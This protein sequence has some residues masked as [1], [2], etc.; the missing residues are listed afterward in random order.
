MSRVIPCAPRSERAIAQVA[1]RL[2][3]AGELN[4]L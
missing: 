4:G 1:T 3:F 2:D